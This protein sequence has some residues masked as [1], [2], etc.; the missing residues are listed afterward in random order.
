MVLNPRE[1]VL[2]PKVGDLLR[3]LFWADDLGPMTSRNVPWSAV[4]A[5]VC[6]YN[7]FYCFRAS[8]TAQLHLMMTSPTSTEGAWK[9]KHQTREH[10]QRV[11][12][13][14][15]GLHA[16][17]TTPVNER[18]GDGHEGEE[19]EGHDS[20]EACRKGGEGDPTVCVA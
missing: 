15:A 17:T 20:H 13:T 18:K 3:P 6:I 7:G 10:A 19:Y 4:L 12:C 8:K 5:T 1:T 14:K 2:P 9:Q 16:T 11:N